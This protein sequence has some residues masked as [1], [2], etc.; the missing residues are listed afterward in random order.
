MDTARIEAE[1]LLAALERI[2]RDAGREILDVL[3]AG[4]DVIWKSDATPVTEA[5]H[6]AEA[7]ILAGLRAYFPSIPVVAE[8]AD[9]EGQC[10]LCD[11]SSRFFLVDP[12]DGTREFI[13][14]RDD[15]TVNI[16]LVDGGVPVAGVVYAPKTGMLYSGAAGHG[17]FVMQVF[18]D[19]TVSER[20]AARVEARPASAGADWVALTSRNHLTPETTRYLARFKDCQTRQLGSSLKFCLL[21]QGLAD[22]YP[23]LGP[24]M[25][26]DTAA[27]DAVLRA[28][29]GTTLTLDDQ[30]LVYGAGKQR[31]ANPDFVS[32]GKRRR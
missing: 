14:G 21:A 2:A 9:A 19:G 13:A 16:A 6:R 5:D 4:A 23:R 32:W 11:A 22:V 12:L 1:R 15:F 26:W 3:G 29:G 17:A 28:A 20:R 8:E 10:P 31:Y 30:P 7:V 25:Q 27:G 18:D 24:T